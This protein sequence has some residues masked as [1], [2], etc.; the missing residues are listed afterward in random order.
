MGRT[1]S[2]DEIGIINSDWDLINPAT[3]ETLATLKDLTVVLAQ[4]NRNIARPTYLN[5]VTGALRAIVESGSIAIT[6]WTITA[7]TNVNGMSWYT[8]TD[9]VWAISR[10]SFASN[11]ISNIP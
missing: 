5:G 3:E 6:S 8:T 10:A 7:L 1:S 9:Q 2:I 11:V 4:L